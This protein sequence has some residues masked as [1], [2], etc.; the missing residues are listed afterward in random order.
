MKNFS[1]VNILKSFLLI[2]LLSSVFVI[3]TRQ[4]ADDQVANYLE[5]PQNIDEPSSYFS[6]GDQ[7]QVKEYRRF[8]S[9]SPLEEVKQLDESFYVEPCLQQ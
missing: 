2:C 9:K 6:L 4:E 7:L 8:Y 5:S 3:A 1:L